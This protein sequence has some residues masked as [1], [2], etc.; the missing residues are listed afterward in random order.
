MELLLTGRDLV[1]DEHQAR[2]ST[3][4]RVNNQGILAFA[5]IF[6]RPLRKRTLRLSN[7]SPLKRSVLTK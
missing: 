2:T 6:K 5:K 4:A 7:P 1:G 3:A